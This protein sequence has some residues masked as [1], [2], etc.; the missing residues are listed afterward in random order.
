MDPDE[1]ERR[2]RAQPAIDDGTVHVIV[3]R[4]PGGAHDLPARATLDPDGGIVGD[5]WSA[6]ARPHRD[7]QVTLMERRVASLFFAADRLHVPG[8]NLI[9]DLDLSV[10]ALPVGARLRA[11]SAVLE[12][13]AKPHT[14]CAKFR[15]KT[16]AGALAWINDAAHLDRRLRGVNARIVE[17]GEV[18]IG[19][20]LVRL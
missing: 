12:I 18:A 6:A 16:D 11:G 4:K 5:R 19:D 8:D 9:V 2:F 7:A 15:A 14:G 10:G 3:L 20:R 1:L 13:T 17:G